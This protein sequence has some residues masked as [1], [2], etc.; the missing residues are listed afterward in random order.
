MADV[1]KEVSSKS[2]AEQKIMKD[3]MEK[4]IAAGNSVTIAGQTFT[5]Q[6]EISKIFDKNAAGSLDDVYT[7]EK[8]ATEKRL[9]KEAKKK[10][11]AH[12]QSQIASGD[13]RTIGDSLNVMDKLTAGTLG[14]FEGEAG[15]N[16]RKAAGDSIKENLGNFSVVTGVK[17]DLETTLE[18][19]ETA[20]S[21]ARNVL[22]PAQEQELLKIK[23]EAENQL[24]EI[25]I[26]DNP[27]SDEK[28]KVFKHF[29]EKG[30]LRSNIIKTKQKTS[31][32]LS[33]VFNKATISKI[34]N[35]RQVAEADLTSI[36]ASFDAA[37]TRAIAD[38]VLKARA[39][40]DQAAQ[41]RVA[42][43][44]LDALKDII[45]N[46]YD[47]AKKIGEKAEKTKEK[48]EEVF[49]GKKKEEGK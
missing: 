41:E 33:G 24:K 36:K 6:A 31:E 35:E 30:A 18:E 19:V 16:V 32:I 10:Y 12:R 17:K 25:V 11:E 20:L 22:T 23:T 29:K 49:D 40:A 1:L 39:F 5:Q 21:V 26:S 14:N 43:E 28:L 7:R 15:K 38:P 47:N 27:N 8:E 46:G 48:M 2:E 3:D 44:K 4:E 37:A 9:E 45:K 13:A 42:R 34:E